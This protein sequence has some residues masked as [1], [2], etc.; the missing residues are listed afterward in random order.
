MN[1]REELEVNSF[2]GEFISSLKTRGNE[3]PRIYKPR[4]MCNKAI[5]EDFL[6][7]PDPKEF[8]KK[9]GALLLTGE[10]KTPE[11]ARVYVETSDPLLPV[12]LEKC[13]N[14]NCLITNVGNLRKVERYGRDKIIIYTD[15]MK[16][17]ARKIGVK[18]WNAVKYIRQRSEE[19][20]EIRRKVKRVPIQER[21]I[22]RSEIPPLTPEE[23]TEIEK[24][25]GEHNR[26]Q[27]RLIQE[28]I[29]RPEPTPL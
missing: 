25:V 19:W 17:E 16:I 14:D 18:I 20:K 8:I 7:F 12:I 23:A 15:Q 10:Y 27:R 2:P 21:K 4:G 26:E 13:N 3:K 22:E 11:G 28:V 24:I 29:G 1:Y 6:E 9:G 5:Y